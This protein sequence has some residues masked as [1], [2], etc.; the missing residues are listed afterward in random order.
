MAT[1]VR[2]RARVRGRTC[3]CGPTRLY[4]LGDPRPK[5]SLG[6]LDFIAWQQA[7]LYK[8]RARREGPG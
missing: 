5:R 8:G 1:R 4:A 7:Q 2:P 3:V 6:Y